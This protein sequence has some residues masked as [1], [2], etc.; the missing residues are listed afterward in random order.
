MFYPNYKNSVLAFHLRPAGK[1]EKSVQIIYFKFDTYTYSTQDIILTECL[2]CQWILKIFAYILFIH[3]MSNLTLD[4]DWKVFSVRDK[5]SDV[6]SYLFAWICMRIS[7]R[8]KNK[9]QTLFS[10]DVGLNK[11]LGEMW[12]WFSSLFSPLHNSHWDIQSRELNER[13]LSYFSVKRLM[14]PN[15]LLTNLFR[16]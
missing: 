9:S 6:V 10:Y 15:S 8:E 2:C 12:H 16:H 3:N 14:I 13:G 7:E 4:N 5:I 11:M 1:K